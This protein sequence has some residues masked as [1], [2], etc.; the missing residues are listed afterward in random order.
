M[1][2]RAL[3]ATIDEVEMHRIALKSRVRLEAPRH[4][5]PGHLLS[6]STFA[7]VASRT[8]AM[9]CMRS[10]CRIRKGIGSE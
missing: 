8:L 5:L 2:S 7:V 4:L 1:V 3:L 9:W 6:V 10:Q